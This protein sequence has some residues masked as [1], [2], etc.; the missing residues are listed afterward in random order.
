MHGVNCPRH[1]EEAR[2]IGVFLSDD[3]D[4]SRNAE[5]ACWS[6]REGATF[7]EDEVTNGLV[8]RE[9]F[10]TRLDAKFREEP[11]DFLDDT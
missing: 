7:V 10:T 5:N 9:F 8:T 3:A 2:A 11:S 6:C 1:G 4:H